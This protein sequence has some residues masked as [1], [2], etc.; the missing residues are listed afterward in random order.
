MKY[1]AP[2]T[3]D[4]IPVKSSTVLISSPIEVSGDN[5]L[6]ASYN[7]TNLGST[8]NGF[9]GLCLATGA[10]LTWAGLEANGILKLTGTS[11][12]LLTLTGSLSMSNIA[13]GTLDYD[14]FIVSDDGL[15]KYRT[16]TQIL[17]DISGQPLDASLTSI[18]GLTYASGSFIAL[19]AED[20]YA[21]RTYA[22]TLSDIDGANSKL[23]NLEDTVAINKALL[24][25]SDDTGSFTI[26]SSSYQWYSG[27]IGTTLHMGDA[28]VINFDSGDITITHSSNL[29]TIAGGALEVADHGTATNPEVVNVTYGTGSS[30]P[31]AAADF[32]VGTLYFE[33]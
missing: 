23:S 32:P 22:Q 31:G 19:T 30:T 13:A 17:S 25:A 33:Y 2:L 7:T 26:G 14:K 4:Y 11:T 3:T 9:S 15:L 12:N 18:S 27:Y 28:S 10:E 24:P 1:E 16:G 5:L 21:V 20:T 8:N 29:L 6:P